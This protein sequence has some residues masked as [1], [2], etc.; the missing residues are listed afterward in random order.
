MKTYALGAFELSQLRAFDDNVDTLYASA[1]ATRLH[2]IIRIPPAVQSSTL[3][4]VDLYELRL[5]LPRILPQE[6]EDE[7]AAPASAASEKEDD[8]NEWSERESQR[9]RQRRRLLEEQHELL[10]MLQTLQHQHKEEHRTGF[11]ASQ[12]SW[13]SALMWYFRS[14]GMDCYEFS[15][16]T[17]RQ[18]KQNRRKKHRRKLNPRSK[19]RAKSMMIL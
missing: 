19:V 3:T 9:Y 6:Q 4:E 13:T 18:Q 1:D 2:Q 12:R 14:K 5:L 17:S 15:G 8:R 11:A 7:E 10:H 16:S